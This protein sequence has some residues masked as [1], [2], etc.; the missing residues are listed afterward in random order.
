MPANA[1]VEP[2]SFE[3][4]IALLKQLGLEVGHGEKMSD[5]TWYLTTASAG[6]FRTEVAG[7]GW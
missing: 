1:A 2:L 5:G 6:F 4:A 3:E 7:R